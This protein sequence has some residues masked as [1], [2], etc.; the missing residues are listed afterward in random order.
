MLGPTCFCNLYVALY[1]PAPDWVNVETD[2]GLVDNGDATV[3]DYYQGIHYLGPTYTN[4]R[5]RF[6]FELTPTAHDA[7]P[8][9]V[10]A[11][12]QTAESDENDTTQPGY[13][14]LIQ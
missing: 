10:T 13:S 8:E 3:S 4:M 7:T 9:Q 14:R 5:D 6:C 2:S 1:A 12:E 11:A